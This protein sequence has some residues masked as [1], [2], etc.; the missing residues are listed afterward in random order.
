MSEVILDLRITCTHTCT[1]PQANTYMYTYPCHTYILAKNTI[2][3]IFK[4]F[5]K[6]DLKKS[7]LKNALEIY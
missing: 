6:V 4:V 2:L 1:P 3:N 5:F 7:T